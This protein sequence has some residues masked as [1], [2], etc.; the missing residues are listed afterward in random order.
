M[1]R[2]R[3]A[4]FGLGVSAAAVVLAL[5]ASVAWP[6]GDRKRRNLEQNQGRSWCSFSGLN[7]DPSPLDGSGPNGPGGQSQA[8]GQDVKWVSPIRTRGNLACSANQK[9]AS[10]ST[11]EPDALTSRSITSGRSASILDVPVRRASRSRAA[12]TLEQEEARRDIRRASIFPCGTRVLAVSHC[13]AAEG[14]P[15]GRA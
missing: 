6:G 12:S 2:R 15:Q 7:D 10:S 3:I 5:S 11:T 4:R 1:A 13:D 8:Y 9:D 14:R